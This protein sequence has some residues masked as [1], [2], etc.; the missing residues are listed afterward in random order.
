MAKVEKAMH[1]FDDITADMS[2]DLKCTISHGKETGAWLSVTPTTVNR[3][4]LSAQ[5]F[6][7]ALLMHYGCTPP[8]LPT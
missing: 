4:E 3:M 1:A 2:A 5:E 7:D 6:R 8:D